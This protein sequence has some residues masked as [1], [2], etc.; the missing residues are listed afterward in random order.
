MK[1][2]FCGTEIVLGFVISQ[3]TVEEKQLESEFF[4]LI[5]SCKSCTIYVCVWVTYTH[6]HTPYCEQNTST[7]ITRKSLNKTALDN[8][9]TK[10]RDKDK[11]TCKPSHSLQQIQSK[12]SVNQSKNADTAPM[13]MSHCFQKLKTMWEDTVHTAVLNAKLLSLSMK[14][15]FFLM[16]SSVFPPYCERYS[17]EQ[18]TVSWYSHH[19]LLCW[20]A[21]RGWKLVIIWILI[22]SYIY[23][24][25]GINYILV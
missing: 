19:Y 21:G 4:V 22:S 2:V 15:L 16:C 23:K 17:V 9:T 3:D 13:T 11:V 5:S 14:T 24:I 1:C 25:S 10:Y 12:T 8:W 20:R 18:K 7:Y 6:T